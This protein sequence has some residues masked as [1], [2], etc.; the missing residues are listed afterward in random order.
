MTGTLS[1]FA[2]A[3]RAARERMGISQQEAA[4][5]AGVPLRTYHAWEAGRNEPSLRRYTELAAALGLDA[6][7]EGRIT[8]DEAARRLGIHPDEHE[9]EGPAVLVITVTAG[10]QVSTHELRWHHGPPVSVGI[11]AKTNGGARG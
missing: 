10:D 2:T 9:G 7:D 1:P 6:P 8:A 4:K 3:L 5:R 11:G